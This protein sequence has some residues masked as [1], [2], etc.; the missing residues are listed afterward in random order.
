MIHVVIFKA[1]SLLKYPQDLILPLFDF[2]LIK[3]LFFFYFLRQDFKLSLCVCVSKDNFVES[4]SRYTGIQQWTQRADSY[5]KHP[6]PL[7]HPTGPAAHIF[8]KRKCL[9][10]QVGLCSNA[11][12]LFGRQRQEDDNFEASLGYIAS[13]CF[14]KHTHIQRERERKGEE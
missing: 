6:H 3:E 13:P 12:L 10:G 9:K 7:S 11:I 5:D 2:F 8:N 14:K 1:Q 4:S